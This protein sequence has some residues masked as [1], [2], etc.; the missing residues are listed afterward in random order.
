MKRGSCGEARRA[1]AGR[2]GR[3]PAGGAEWSERGA[4]TV[5]S[6]EFS[7]SMKQKARPGGGRDLAP[8][9]GRKRRAAAGAARAQG[10]PRGRPAGAAG[11]RGGG[12]RARAAAGAAAGAARAQGLPR[13]RP[14]GRP[15]RKGCRGGG[16]RAAARG[17]KGCRGGGRGGGPRANNRAGRPTRHRATSCDA[18]FFFGPLETTNVIDFL[19]AYE[20]LPDERDRRWGGRTDR[21]DLPRGDLT[22]A[23]R[24]GVRGPA[25]IRARLG[26]DR[27]ARRC[28]VARA[29]SKSSGRRRRTQG[30]VGHCRGRRPERKR[31][32]YTY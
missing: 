14:R 25:G 18:F 17:R 6:A 30:R 5:D 10:L 31:G 26:Q 27:P 13:G 19:Y 7:A 1:D 23:G 22:P 21:A 15:A 24:N 16:P 29:A 3:P 28:G 12:P 32:D 4:P 9:L 8:I 2:S 20:P 11:G